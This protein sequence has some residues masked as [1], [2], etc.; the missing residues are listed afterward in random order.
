MKYMCGSSSRKLPLYLK[1]CYLQL[2]NSAA[3]L[4]MF[5]FC[6]CSVWTEWLCCQGYLCCP[7]LFTFVRI[8]R[9]PS[10][11]R[12]GGPKI[13]HIL[14]REMVYDAGGYRREPFPMANI[15]REYANQLDSKVSDIGS[16]YTP[17]IFLFSLLPLTCDLN[18]NF[19][20][21]AWS[22]INTSPISDIG[23][24]TRPIPFCK[25]CHLLCCRFSFRCPPEP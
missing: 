12:R 20:D 9:I 10:R 14:C 18:F 1:S 17:A 7:W 4:W 23:P 11:F 3:N 2:P 15:L 5:R 25:E 6:N 19:D 24:V 16:F 22:S 13:E 21:P 8:P